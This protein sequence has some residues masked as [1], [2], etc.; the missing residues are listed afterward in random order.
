MKA[1]KGFDRSMRCRGFQFEEG[2]TYKEDK[3]ELC[4]AGFHACE[5]PLDVWRYYSPAD[6]CEYHE[7][8][9]EDVSEKWNSN[10]SKVCGKRIR[11]G[12]KLGIEELVNASVSIYID[13]ANKDAQDALIDNGKTWRRIAAS[14]HKACIGSSGEWACIAESG[15]EA[16][17]GSSGYEACIAASGHKA[18]IGSSGKW[19][20][21][22]ASGHEACIGSSGKWTR[23]AASGNEAR[24]GVSGDEAR[25]GASGDEARIAVSGHKARIGASGDEARIAVSGHKAR[26]AA[27][28]DEAQIETRGTNCVMMCAGQN[29]RA[30][31]QN[32]SWIVLTEWLNGE[33]NVVA[34]RIDGTMIK[35]DTWYVLRDG[36]LQ[37]VDANE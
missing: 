35:A 37:E 21:I 33:P 34:R 31:G 15:Y 29:S 27:S 9:L 30:K 7:V 20:S 3:A 5:N 13:K 19:A 23:I 11:I 17:I 25:I 10:D 24:I 26:I 32:G 22:A 18:C 4:K 16:C 12:A 1:Y 2:K 6:G 28:G 36:Q 8:E 14:E